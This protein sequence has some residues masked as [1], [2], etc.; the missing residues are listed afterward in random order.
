MAPGGIPFR[1]RLGVTGHRTLTEP[2]RIARSIRSILESRIWELFDRPPAPER[3]TAAPVF[4]VLTPLSEGADRLV[5]KEALKLPGTQVEVP[6]PLAKED[7]VRDFGARASVQEFE[8]LCK[9]ARHVYALRTEPLPPAAPDAA[10]AEKERKRAYEDV[11]RHVVDRSDVLIAVWDGRPS[12]GRGG[13]A[14]IVAYARKK[15]RPLIIVSSEEPERVTLEKGCGLSGRV[16][17]RAGA[18]D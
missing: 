4:T 5:A 12:R 13:T 6:L 18:G 9:K 3:R 7:Y 15:K 16:Y 14:E 11:G 10:R 8:T 17:E 1:I 2:E